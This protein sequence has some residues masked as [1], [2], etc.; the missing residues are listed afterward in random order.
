[1]LTAPITYT[2]GSAPASVAISSL[3]GETI[4]LQI[5]L[6][7]ATGA[8]RDCRGG[9]VSWC[10][11]RKNAPG[12]A[13]RRSTPGTES[14]VHVIL[15]PASVT[16]LLDGVYQHDA[17]FE[18]ADGATEMVG[19]LS[20][21]TLTRAL[22]PSGADVTDPDGP[23]EIQQ[24]IE[25]DAYL[26][27]I[28]GTQSVATAPAVSAP[29]GAPTQFVL[30]VAQLVGAG[31]DP[32]AVGT[33]HL[34]RDGAPVGPSIPLQQ[35]SPGVFVGEVGLVAQQAYGLSRGQWAAFVAA[36]GST[37]VAVMPS[38]LLYVAT[39]KPLNL[40]PVV[41]LTAPGSGATV[42]VGGLVVAF[43]ATDDAELT[44][45]NFSVLVD[46]AIV[47]APITLLSGSG[48][49]T[50]T[51]A[52]TVSLATAGAH[53]VAVRC[54]DAM[55]SVTTSSS[56]SVTAVQ[57]TLALNAPA[58]GASVDVGQPISLM[59]TCA[60][61]MPD[62]TA[63]L[64]F[65]GATQVAATTMS[66]GTASSSYAPTAE[67]TLSITARVTTVAGAVNSVAASVVVA[68]ALPVI[69]AV[70]PASAA[71]LP[72][73]TVAVSATITHANGRAMLARF[74][75]DSGSWMAM[76]NVGSTFSGV[77][78]ALTLDTSYT[79]TI[80]ATDATDWATPG[81][82]TTSTTTFSV[83]YAT[84]WNGGVLAFGAAYSSTTAPSSGALKI[85]LSGAA[86]GAVN[87]AV[88]KV[89]VPA[90][91]T[92]LGLALPDGYTVASSAALAWVDAST[93]DGFTGWRPGC[94]YTALFRID[95]TAKTITISDRCALNSGLPSTM[96]LFRLTG[97]TP[98]LTGRNPDGATAGLA[99]AALSTLQVIDPHAA[100]DGK[101]QGTVVA[102]NATGGVV[103]PVAGDTTGFT[104]LGWLHC[105]TAWCQLMTLPAE[106]RLP[107]MLG[108]GVA[109]ANGSI[110]FADG[111]DPNSTAL[112]AVD[113]NG[114]PSPLGKWLHLAVVAKGSVFDV[115]FNGRKILANT[116]MSKALASWAGTAALGGG[117]GF[118]GFGGQW[119]VTDTYAAHLAA[120]PAQLSADQIGAHMES[121]APVPTAL[122]HVVCLGSSMQV[123]VDTGNALADATRIA[124]G[125]DAS[126]W[127]VYA[128]HGRVV[129][130]TTLDDMTLNKQTMLA[131]MDWSCRGGIAV[132]D[133]G[134]VHNQASGMTLQAAID[135]DG[136]FRVQV[137]H[138]LRAGW[139]VVVLDWAE[140][141]TWGGESGTILRQVQEL[142]FAAMGASVIRFRTREVLGDWTT[143]SYYT[144]DGGSHI[145]WS[146]V[147][148]AKIAPALASLITSLRSQPAPMARPSWV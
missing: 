138:L 47:D 119:S 12:V 67:G 71:V 60:P 57:P 91:C 137:S 9:T 98:D 14:G 63:V 44:A 7:T 50:V 148:V 102:D 76:T 117:V 1:M 68:D 29:Y 52:C 21:W 75:L 123:T 36:R 3:V 142:F 66:G 96:R 80:Q 109:F 93:L 70:T 20:P 38:D 132:L 59:A 41:S 16:G 140:S 103:L 4:A 42:A 129:I 136:L 58:G 73:G 130:N 112:T 101:T 17:W 65:N 141:T 11:G 30:R 83:S 55:G 78:A 95:T 32:A 48:T 64:F 31:A 5:T 114:H 147:G 113:A 34:S 145:H 72:A 110:Y 40:P 24:T 111:N 23:T 133:Y 19:A 120:V 99:A 2:A 87:G 26:D 135:A 128:T 108:I 131:N 86:T 54:T 127:H 92:E 49:T 79:L 6:K 97:S 81:A 121:T 125:V 27:V 10:F 15:I 77:S 61:A 106:T 51:G 37:W 13:L 85:D 33:L 139:R 82:I 94:V 122:P 22:G 89:S 118:G 39:G 105:G 115:Y 134:N 126:L 74:R 35:A 46:G 100:T 45:A 62:G 69:S 143:D 25:V 107:T 56:R 8:A 43:A 144:D 28:G 90:G 53:T 18:G 116:A 104:I 88:L 84:P 124:A 146:S